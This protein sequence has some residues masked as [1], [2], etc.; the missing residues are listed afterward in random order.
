MLLQSR[1]RGLTQSY[2]GRIA[3]FAAQY[4]GIEIDRPMS[5]KLATQNRIKGGNWITFSE[6][7][8][9]KNSVGSIGYVSNW[10]NPSRYRLTTGGR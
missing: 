2:A 9:W 5:H 1:N 8:S 4:P 10:A 3:A 6:L 7:C